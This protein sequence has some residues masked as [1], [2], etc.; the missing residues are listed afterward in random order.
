MLG[1]ALSGLLKPL[2]LEPVI[3]DEVILLT[4]P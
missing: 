3:R 4:R 2:G 1:E